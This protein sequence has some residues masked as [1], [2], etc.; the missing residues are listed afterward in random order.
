MPDPNARI[1]GGQTGL[2]TAV[3]SI[4]SRT[5]PAIVTVLLGAGADPMFRYNN[6][7]TLLYAVVEWSDNLGIVTALLKAGADP[8][9][10]TEGGQSPL[11]IALGE[12]DNPAVLKMLKS[13]T[14]H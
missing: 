13:A 10:L 8:N 7:S 4:N 6:G 5:N 3:Y 12:V 11:D 1:E 9:A 14:R 2:Q